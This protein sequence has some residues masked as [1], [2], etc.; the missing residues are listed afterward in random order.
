LI[1][2]FEQHYSWK[3]NKRKTLFAN[4]PFISEIKIIITM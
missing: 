2:S 3:L 1:F 4:H